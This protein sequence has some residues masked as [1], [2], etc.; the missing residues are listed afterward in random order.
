M[1]DRTWI[2]DDKSGEPQPVHRRTD[3]HGRDAVYHNS[4]PQTSNHALKEQIGI[5]LAAYYTGDTHDATR[6]AEALADLL[7][8]LRATIDAAIATA[9]EGADG[10][11]EQAADAMES[12]R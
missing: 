7:P 2:I 6:V 9:L 11:D 12:R 3:S 1:S 10:T 4:Y 8:S 5:D